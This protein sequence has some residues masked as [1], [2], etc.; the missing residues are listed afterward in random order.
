MFIMQHSSGNQYWT[1]GGTSYSCPLVAGVCALIFQK[2][3]NLTPMEVLQV[4]RST[5]S[6]STNPDNEY[7]W[8][9]INALNAMNLVTVPVELNFI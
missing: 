7:G 8:G 1:G 6:R 3:P 2:N 5:A 9:I 4:L